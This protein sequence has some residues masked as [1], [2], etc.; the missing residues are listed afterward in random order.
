MLKGGS[1]R[2]R[3]NVSHRRIVA[4][5]VFMARGDRDAILS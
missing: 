4:I 1:A 2:Q 5:I 3:G